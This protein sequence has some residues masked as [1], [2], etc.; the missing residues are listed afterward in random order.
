M[1]EYKALNKINCDG[2]VV[3]NKKLLQA[4]QEAEEKFRAFADSTATVIFIGQEGKY[5]YTNPY[6]QELLGYSEEEFYKMDLWDVNHPDYKETA[7][8]RAT[9][10][11]K[12]VKN[13]PKRYEMQVVTRNGKPIWM[14]ISATTIT[15]RGKPAIIASAFDI[16]DRKKMEQK[17]REDEE[18]W[19]FALEG[20]HVSVWDLNIQTDEVYFSRRFTDML[21]YEGMEVGNHRNDWTKFVHPEDLDEGNEKY[22]KHFKGETP[23]YTH[24]FRARCK[25]G[26]Y[27]WL[28]ARGKVMEW[29][30]DGKPLRFVGTHT[31]IT[32][33]KK[34]EE[35]IIY[36]SYH[37]KL[38]GLYNRA[39]FEKKIKEYKDKKYLPLS[40]IT[41]DVNGLKLAN[42]VFG[43]KQGDKLLKVISKILLKSVRKEDI[44]ARW[45]GDEFAIVLPNTEYNTALEICDRI[46]EA[47]EKADKKPIQPSIS[48]GCSTKIEKGEDINIVIKEA[49]DRM[50]RQKLLISSSVRGAIISSLEKS[51][52]EKSFET[53]EH[54]RRMYKI[55]KKIGKHL[56]LNNSQL[57]ELGLFCILHDIGKIAISDSILTKP[58]RLDE[59]EW[60]KMMQHPEIGYRIAQSSKELSHISEYILTHHERW[61]GQGYPQALKG[62]DI[63]KLSRILAIVDAYDVMTNGRVYKEGVSHE[64]AIE[65]IR[66]CAGTQFDPNLVEV[67]VEVMKDGVNLLGEEEDLNGIHGR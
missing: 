46:T 38:T 9:A 34:A 20:S 15:Y 39:Y 23:L 1:G 28:L 12:G 18:R 31:D 29:T 63:P 7:K 59:D 50:Y 47:C 11:E 56:G 51:L 58:S 17:I 33:R 65:E 24:E 66:R 35:E 2:K 21:G 49:E 52:F 53:E 10:R 36:L 57:D 41:G 32:D 25:D 45:G 3:V 48:L 8:I 54:T 30:K 44:V 19:Q 14:D 4:L 61:D 55:S 64:E 43:H 40:I 6:Y 60:R 26:S 62:E 67:F 13:I 5:V 27:K 42:D 22:D 16:T 37:D